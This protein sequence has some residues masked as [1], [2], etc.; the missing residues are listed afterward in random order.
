MG[1]FRNYTKPMSLQEKYGVRKSRM[2]DCLQVLST[3]VN[4]RSQLELAVGVD[5]K[6]R[7]A[8]LFNVSLC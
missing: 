6:H 8:E 7:W 2:Q 3:M 5:Y 1:W 4:M